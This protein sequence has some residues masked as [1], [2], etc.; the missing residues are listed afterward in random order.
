MRARQRGARCIPSLHVD[1]AGEGMMFHRLLLA[2][3]TRENW[4]MVFFGMTALGTVGL[5]G[6]AFYATYYTVRPV[7][8]KLVLEEQKAQLSKH[9]EAKEAELAGI[10]TK[11]TNATKKL[12]IF[13][14]KIIFT[15]TNT[16]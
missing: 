3:K 9:L 7:Y 12:E 14:N 8:Q 16:T 10:S 2:L 15:T 1:D 13:N 4:R 5:A 11:L 6:A